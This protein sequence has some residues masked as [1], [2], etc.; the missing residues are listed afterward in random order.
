ML[1]APERQSATFEI[2]PSDTMVGA[3]VLG[4]DLRRPLDEAAFE[5]VSAAL[6]SFSV[7]CFR[8]QVLAPEQ[9][10]AFS[11]RFG[12]LQ[13][14][15]RSEFNKPGYPEVYIVSNVLVDGKPIGSQDAGR[16][17]HSD[18]CYLRKPSRASLLYAL[19]VPQCDGVSLGDTLFASAGAAYEDLPSEMKRRV[20]GLRAV[21]SY[22]AMYDRKASE[23]GLPTEPHR[24]SEKEQ[25]SEGCSAPGRSDPPDHRPQMH[26]CLRR[27]YNTDS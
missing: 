10:I 26:L 12:P 24:R 3:E 20:E 7:V 14:N 5:K 4:L 27:I 21:N 17:W 1:D 2:R 11:R 23:F 25:I 9:H 6:D 22:N 15:V 13:V 16:Y 18:L 19:E 8:N